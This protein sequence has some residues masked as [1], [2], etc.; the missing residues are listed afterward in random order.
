MSL[1][2]RLSD[3]GAH[4]M[5]LRVGGDRHIHVELLV[6]PVGIEVSVSSYG[7]ERKQLLGWQTIEAAKMNPLIERIDYFVATIND[8]V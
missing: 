8:R 4:A 3:A 1:K 6:L 5:R 2:D 7:R